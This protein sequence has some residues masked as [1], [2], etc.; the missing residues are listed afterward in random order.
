VQAGLP[1][2][3]YQEGNPISGYGQSKMSKTFRKQRWRMQDKPPT[4]LLIMRE[5][6]IAQQIASRKHIFADWPPHRSGGR[7]ALLL[8][9]DH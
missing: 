9:V 4:Q 3:F 2:S 7:L 5:L 1:A 8:V 6:P